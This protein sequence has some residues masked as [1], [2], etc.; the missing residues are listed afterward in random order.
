MYLRMP[1]VAGRGRMYVPV[2]QQMLYAEGAGRSPER[3]LRENRD[4]SYW[5][6]MVSY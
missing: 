5:L 1:H 3:R 6:C 2:S 4:V